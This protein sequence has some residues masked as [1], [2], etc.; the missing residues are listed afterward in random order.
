MFFS[1]LFTQYTSLNCKRI[2]VVHRDVHKI[3]V[4]RK[5]VNR[6]DHE[7]NLKVTKSDVFIAGYDKNL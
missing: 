7:L 2:A 3:E 5:I 4:T 6:G 1:F